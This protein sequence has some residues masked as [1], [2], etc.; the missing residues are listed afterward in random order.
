MATFKIANEVAELLPKMQVVV[1]TAKGL[2][3]RTANPKIASHVQAVVAKTVDMFAANNYS[4]AQ[5]HPRVA[6]YQNTLKAVANVSSKKFPQSNESLLKRVL[7]EKQ[8]GRPIS[9]I[10]DFYNSISIEHAVTAGAFDLLELRTANG[11]LELRL[12][13][14][15][16][17]VFVPLDAASDA[18]PGKVD[19]GE[20]LY[21]QGNTVLTR[22]M[23]WRKSKQALVTDDSTEVMFMSEVF[24]EAEP[25]PEPTALAQAIAE[26]LQDGLQEFFGVESTAAFLGKSLEKLEISL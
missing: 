9:P 18:Q 3:N 10:V 26:S 16:Q 8:A 19:K 17:D 13:D 25:G 14:F 5:S 11:P 4:N 12:A 20:I 15:E 1:V 22:H 2:E 21:A 24:N 7:K 23:A 6:L